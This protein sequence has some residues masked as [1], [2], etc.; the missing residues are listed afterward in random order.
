MYFITRARE[1]GTDEV[2]KEIEGSS[3]EQAHKAF[4]AV[5]Q[6]QWRA[7]HIRKTLK[8][9]PVLKMFDSDGKQIAQGS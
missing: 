4:S 1:D 3:A 7:Y 6:E 2:I 9:W 5:I 8:E